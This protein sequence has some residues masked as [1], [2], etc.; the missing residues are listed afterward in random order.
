M[1]MANADDQIMEQP[2][3]EP[4]NQQ[5]QWD[6]NYTWVWDHTRGWSS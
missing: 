1:Q 5:V 4:D 6:P 2:Q 3:P